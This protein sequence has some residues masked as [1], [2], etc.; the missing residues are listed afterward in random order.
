MAH[1]ANSATWELVRILGRRGIESN[2]EA[3]NTL[4]RAQ[5]TLHRWHEREC[6]DSNDYCS[7]SLERDEDT[8]KPYNVIHPHAGKSYRNVVPDLETGALNRIKAVC[9]PLGLYYYIQ[10]DCRGCSLYV[11]AEPLDDQ[12]YSTQGVACCV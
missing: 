1:S 10:G 8:G 2:F 5:M 7:I 4:R 9:E 6:G 12:N 3:V 11:A